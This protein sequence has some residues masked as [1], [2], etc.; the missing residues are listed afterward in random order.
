MQRLVAPHARVVIHVARL[1]QADHRVDEQARLDLLGRPQRQLLVRPV[2]SGCASGTR[3][4]FVQP[5]L[6]N[7]ARSSRRRVAQ[8]TVV[9]VGDRLHRGYPPADVAGLGSVEQMGDARMLRVCGAEHRGG[10]RLPIRLPDVLDVEDSHHDALLV[11]QRELRSRRQRGRQRFRHVERDRHRPQGPVSQ[12]H[13]RTD[14]VVVA[15][16]KETGERREPA[17]GEQLEVAELARSQIMR[18]PVARLGLQC[19]APIVGGEKID[20]GPAVGGDQMVGHAA[21]PLRWVV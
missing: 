12:A 9:V 15:T 3:P 7:S 20:E 6:A 13:L 4:L 16:A 10:L 21:Y 14:L 5:S 19:G 17:A 2:H 18:R 1:G 8:Q 11:A